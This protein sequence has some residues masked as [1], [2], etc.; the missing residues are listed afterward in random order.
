MTR[1]TLHCSH[2]PH[3]TRFSILI[4]STLFIFLKQ[5]DVVSALVAL[6]AVIVFSYL[7]T[8]RNLP[9]GT[10]LLDGPPGKPLIGNLLQIPSHHSWLKFRNW[11]TRYGDIFRLSIA[12]H[13]HVIISTEE[14]AKDLLRERGTIYST[15]SSCLW[16]LNL[17]AAT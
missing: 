3:L 13:N 16:R 4:P 12:G 17:S 5:N 2:I 9:A 15:A 8:K 7:H 6:S 14:I 11:S 1:K 10:Q